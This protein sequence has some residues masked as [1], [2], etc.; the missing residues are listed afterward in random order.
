MPLIIKGQRENKTNNKEQVQS[1]N[2]VEECTKGDNN[3]MQERSDPGATIMCY[4]RDVHKT[5]NYIL[6]QSYSILQTC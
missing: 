1:R 5:E 4:A 3:D 6:R 2:I